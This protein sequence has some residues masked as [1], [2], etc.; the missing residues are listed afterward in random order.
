MFGLRSI[1]G[2]P[3]LIPMQ[4]LAQR[5]GVRPKSIVHVGAHLAEERGD[6]RKYGVKDVLWIEGNP[7]LIPEIEANIAAYPG[8]RVVCAM[9][10]SEEGAEVAFNVANNGM[11][12]SVLPFGT[13]AER[14][15]EVHYVGQQTAT[16]T[17]IDRLVGGCGPDGLFLALDIQGYELEALRG[18]E[19]TLR[20][21]SVVYAEINVEPLY[22]HCGLLPEVDEFLRMHGFECFTIRMC[23][24]ARKDCSDGGNRYVGWGDGAWRR[25][26]HE[27]RTVEEL[28]GDQ[29][30]VR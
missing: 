20:R 23:G 3:V 19:K 12:S 13:H 4:E 17:T 27:P 28:F 5:H 11:S 7:L 26:E 21:T 2:R 24:C 15:P 14:H 8:H 18:A 25:V 29:I 16:L 10:G 9:V 22:D 30:D 1:D 6:Y